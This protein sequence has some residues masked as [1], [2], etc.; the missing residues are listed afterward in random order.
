MFQHIAFNRCYVCSH[1]LR[2]FRRIPLAQC[3]DYACMLTTIVASTWFAKGSLA[4]TPPDNLGAD[5][6]HGLKNRNQ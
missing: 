4:Q 2:R 5:R 6:V 3:I 1:A